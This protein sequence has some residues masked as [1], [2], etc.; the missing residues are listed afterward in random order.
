MPQRNDPSVTT[1]SASMGVIQW[2]SVLSQIKASPQDVNM[3]PFSQGFASQSSTVHF[4]QISQ[5]ELTVNIYGPLD[6][7]PVW[8]M[9][10]QTVAP[11]PE[12][13]GT[14]NWISAA[15]IGTDSQNA[16][17]YSL[18]GITKSPNK[19]SVYASHLGLSISSQDLH[20]EVAWSIDI[21][22]GNDIWTLA[23]T[24]Y[25]N[26]S[27]DSPD[28]G[29]VKYWKNGPRKANKFELYS[30]PADMTASPTLVKLDWTTISIKYVT[31]SSTNTISTDAMPVLCSNTAFDQS[32]SQI[33]WLL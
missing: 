13:P 1:L 7:G 6:P 12:T 26:Y 21:E 30:I 17:V 3:Y 18:V 16:S 28:V 25:G 32:I 27:I 33:G 2:N 8:N 10:N 14:T 15:H 24:A 19:G 9:Q 29:M 31:L 22:D 23:D 20:A 5:S 4:R 11:I